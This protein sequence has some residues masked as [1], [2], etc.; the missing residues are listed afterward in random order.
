VGAGGDFNSQADES[1]PKL[2]RP[3]QF[4]RLRVNGQSYVVATVDLARR[5]QS[6]RSAWAGGWNESA[7]SVTLRHPYFFLALETP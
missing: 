6:A 1:R 5:L 4:N 2:S 3:G 7:P